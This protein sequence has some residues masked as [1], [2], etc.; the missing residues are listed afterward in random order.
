MPELLAQLG[1]VDVRAACAR[2][3]HP[4]DAVTVA[5]TTAATARAS[6]E[7]ATAGPITIVRHDEY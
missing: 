7:T 5:V 3:F 2:H 6:L 4:D 1:A